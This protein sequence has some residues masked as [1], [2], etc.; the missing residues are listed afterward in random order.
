MP[1]NPSACT[2]LPQASAEATAIAGSDPPAPNKVIAI[3]GRVIA[4]SVPGGR[5]E[6][7]DGAELWGK[8]KW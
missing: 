3:D 7:T 2:T 4:E 1:T 6:S 5:G 8:S